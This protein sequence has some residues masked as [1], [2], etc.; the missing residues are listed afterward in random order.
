MFRS[1]PLL[2]LAAPL[3][4]AP[5]PKGKGPALYFNTRVGDTLVYE[6]TV[7]G[8]VTEMTTVVDSVEEKDGVLT[9]T[10]K[11]KGVTDSTEKVQVTQAGVTILP[12]EGQGYSVP[13]P[14]LKLPAKKGDQWEVP[15]GKDSKVEFRLGYM[16]EEEVEVPA[17]KFKAHRVS[18]KIVPAGVKEF[19]MTVSFWFAPGIGPVKMIGE[20]P[21]PEIVQVLKSFTP[22]K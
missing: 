21:S 15:G 10:I 20:G 13:I 3:F 2:L 5:A 6:Q 16:G 19:G 12:T 17:G 14:M 18:M 4:A 8:K 9:V 11:R 22:G 7:G 1:L